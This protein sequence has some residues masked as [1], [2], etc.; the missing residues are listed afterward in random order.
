MLSLIATTSLSAQDKTS[1]LDSVEQLLLNPEL[2]V[3]ER[4]NQQLKLIRAH[5][6]TS[7]RAWELLQ[8]ND[9]LAKIHKLYYQ[10]GRNAF[11]KSIRFNRQFQL[12]SNYLEAI[13]LIDSMA[14]KLDD[15]KDLT[16]FYNR[17]NANY[18]FKTKEYALSESFIRKAIK[19]AE[20]NN[21]PNYIAGLYNEL[22][23]RQRYQD[24]YFDAINNYL[25][26]LEYDNVKK[27][28]AYSN[29]AKL[30][31]R[32][33]DYEKQLEY[34]ELGRIAAEKENETN[35]H[36]TCSIEKGRALYK[37]GQIDS[38]LKIMKLALPI[39]KN[40]Q[41]QQRGVYAWEYIFKVYNNKGLHQEVI[42]SIDSL[43]DFTPEWTTGLAYTEIGYAYYK[44]QELEKA[45]KWCEEGKKIGLRTESALYIRP[46]C[47]CLQ[48]VYGEQGNYKKAYQNAIIASK[49]D[50]ILY[51]KEKLLNISRALNQKDLK[52]QEELLR[53]EQENR[54]QVGQMRL[55]RTKIFAGFILGLSLLGLLAYYQ[56]K[57]RNKKIAEQNA[58][59]KSN[60]EEKNILIKEVHHRVKNNLQIVSSLL[61]MQ[62]RNIENPAAKEALADG[63]DRVQSIALIHNS[64]FKNDNVSELTTKTY[65]TELTQSLFRT[66]RL[67]HQNIHLNFDIEE[68]D[69][70]IETLISLG[71]VLNEI[72]IDTFKIGFKDQSS[73][74]LNVALSEVQDQ[75]KLCINDNAHHSHLKDN[76]VSDTFGQKVI[77]AFS[78]K[79][80][81]TF[82]IDNTNGTT[83]TMLIKN[84]QKTTNA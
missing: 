15:V 21:Q 64:I 27:S 81:A 47:K 17:A 58:I 40:S 63:R 72:L 29:I 45:I 30:Y 19:E 22:A 2:N 67:P 3:E 76:A 13:A 50:S 75:L 33:E 32:L 38:S 16:V 35:V 59:I 71:L 73:G 44:K 9:S 20:K 77:E 1:K 41:V 57:K 80:K 49:Q 6:Y 84:Y 56:L 55:L 65:L 68:I 36:I 48:K 78:R 39:I 79:L 18:Y 34:A 83:I 52:R 54:D 37:L 66:Y 10:R 5:R 69:L 23:L 42:N 43:K 24:K 12:D 11:Y 28:Y 31:A 51:N 14:N 82:S 60:L 70:S 8:L 25:K 4:V 61:S 74:E 53:L 46:P 7:D 62:M 26:A